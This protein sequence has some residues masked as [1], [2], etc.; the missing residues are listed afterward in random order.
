VPV[1]VADQLKDARA[2]DDGLPDWERLTVEVTVPVGL[3]VP[4][5][6]TD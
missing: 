4:V 2:D 3:T 1:T 6:L 5:T